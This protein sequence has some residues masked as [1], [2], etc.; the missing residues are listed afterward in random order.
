VDVEGAAL[1]GRAGR[2]DAQALVIARP[3]QAVES[4]G[5]ALHVQLAALDAAREGHGDELVRRAC[6]SGRDELAQ[7]QQR[8]EG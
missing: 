6:G 7:R 2:T 4:V 8:G 3:D 1:A 5:R